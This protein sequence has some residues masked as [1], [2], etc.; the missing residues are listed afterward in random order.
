MHAI[1]K[2]LGKWKA[3]SDANVRNDGT[4]VIK[5]TVEEAIDKTIAQEIKV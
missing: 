3:S 2:R 5:C 4:S 1:I